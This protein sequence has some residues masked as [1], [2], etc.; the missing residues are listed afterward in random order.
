MV[1]DRSGRW[2]SNSRKEKPHSEC[3]ANS[4]VPFV[5]VMSMVVF[6]WCGQ[7]CCPKF[8]ASIGLL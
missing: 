6:G 5:I 1:H 3:D 8:F 2:V 4:P 7:R